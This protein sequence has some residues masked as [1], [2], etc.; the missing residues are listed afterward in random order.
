MGCIKAAP[1]DS[2]AHLLRVKPLT[3][4]GALLWGAPLA[5]VEPSPGAHE[6]TQTSVA[7]VGNIVLTLIGVALLIILVVVVYYVAT[8][9]AH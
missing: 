4:S 9:E 6:P 3:E 1:P 2:A 7:Q 5:N 8:Y